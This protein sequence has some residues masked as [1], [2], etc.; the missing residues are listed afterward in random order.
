M[1]LVILGLFAMLMLAASS[2]LAHR[3]VSGAWRSQRDAARQVRAQTRQ[4][5]QDLRAQ[6]REIREETRRVHEEIRQ[7]MRD[8]HRDLHN[9]Y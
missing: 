5:R 6:Q 2:T 4:L 1:K 7:Q 3:E 9:V 8:L